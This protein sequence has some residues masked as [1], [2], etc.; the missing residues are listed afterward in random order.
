MDKSPDGLPDAPDTTPLIPKI[1]IDG[2]QW[3]KEVLSKK[4]QALNVKSQ[5]M[6]SDTDT[7]RHGSKKFT[8]FDK[9]E[10]VD[11]SYFNR[12][13][14][15]EAVEDQNKIDDSVE[16]F[17]L[18]P[19]QE[20]AFRIVANHATQGGIAPLKMYLGGMGGTGKS[21]VIKALIDFFK[22][23]NESHRFM[24][25]APTGTAAALLSGFTYHSVLGINDRKSLDSKALGKIR[26]RLKG[27]DYI[28]LDEVSMVSCYDMYK[29][30]ARLAMVMNSHEE[31]FGG[32]SMIFAG[33]FAQLAPAMK[34]PAL[35]S[36]N[37]GT[38][39]HSRMSVRHQEA[40]IGKALWH[41][42]TTVVILRQN[43]RQNSQT[44]EDA[45]FRQALE[46]MRYKACTKEDV[47]FLISRIAGRGPGRPK[48]GA[49]RFRNVSIITAWNAH[50]DKLN[51]LGSSRF[52]AETGQELVHFYSVDKLSQGD[53]DKKETRN[54]PL[55]ERAKRI[56]KAN[57]ITTKLQQE[58]WDLPP[59]ATGH[60]PGK[61]S[62][63]I[64]LPVMIRNNDATELCMTKGQE[65]TVAGWCSAVG[66]QGQQILDV[67]FVKLIN[68]PSP[69]QFEGLPE[70]VVPL[71]SS[72]HPASCFLVDDTVIRIT[73]SQIM[74]LPNFGMTD[75]ASQGKTRPDNPVDLNNCTNHQSVYTCL[76]RSSTAAGTIIVQGFDEAKIM[77]GASGSL[78]QEF[79][80]LELLDE[81]TKMRYEGNIPASA[82]VNGHRRNI[83]I[84]QYRNWKGMDHVPSDI[85]PSISWSKSNPFPLLPEVNDTPWLIITKDK[86]N[87]ETTY[88][89]DHS[90]FVPAKASPIV[91]SK[92]RKADDTPLISDAKKRHLVESAGF[93]AG[94]IGLVWDNVNY[95][96]AYDSLFSI[97]HS[98]WSMNRVSWGSLFNKTNVKLK[99]L[100]AGFDMHLHDRASIE[101]IRDSVRQLLREQNDAL[102]PM[103]AIGMN[104]ADLADFMMKTSQPVAVSAI[105]CVDC[106]YIVPSAGRS[107]YYYDL[108][109][110]DLDIQDTDTIAKIFGRLLSIQSS[111]SCD[112]C[113]G[114][115]RKNTRF[116]SAPSIMV[117][118]LPCTDIA[119][120]MQ[121]KIAEKTMKLRGAVYYAHNHYTSRI[122]TSDNIIWFHDG[123]S[124]GR[125]MIKQG[126]TDKIGPMFFNTCDGS[127][128]VLLVYSCD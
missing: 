56:Y 1:N 36:H 18:N 48:I 38:Q 86:K 115:M 84:R 66:P 39:I 28:F 71:T 37:V 58:L 29:I 3:R 109:R 124:T 44:P 70:N 22:N 116:T 52:A 5:H 53:E 15:A 7:N 128:I 118:H 111:R 42:I 72:S 63:C 91:D 89:P 77:G 69:V 99:T 62:L 21:Q 126:S 100:A 88:E 60:L 114:E 20:R 121:M 74:V 85:H 107:S 87:S 17:G 123:I 10:I 105:E 34:A 61:L 119:I 73:R 102:F 33:D 27:V 24:V 65:G 2:T 46:N 68:P 113:G 55:T 90:R 96:C 93:L 12:D 120:N 101:S 8:G 78:R 82:S 25:L 79:R 4:Q 108:Q 95:S 13:F 98:I 43:M 81:I 64:G 59:A 35:Y 104:V 6:P 54:K 51:E 67:L 45:K 14:K 106:D 103:G 97:L 23:R 80:E 75:Y 40:A 117:F 112:N 11:A 47:A 110:S 76:S 26:D 19:E 32:I 83:L 49:K 125:S 50:K 122:I 41:Q 9:V 31:P 57:R 127:Q 16:A 92:K 94:P 30:C